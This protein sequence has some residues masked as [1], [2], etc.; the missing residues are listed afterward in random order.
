MASTG[1]AVAHRVASVHSEGYEALFGPLPRLD[2]L[3]AVPARGGDAAARSAL[4]K[5]SS[6]GERR[7][8]GMSP[9]CQCRKGRSTL[10]LRTIRHQ[11]TPL[12]TVWARP[13]VCYGRGPGEGNDR[14]DARWRS[15]R[16]SCVHPQGQGMHRPAHRRRPAASPTDHTTIRASAVAGPSRMTG[17]ERGRVIERLAGRA[18]QRR[19]AEFSR[20]RRRARLTPESALQRGS[21]DSPRSLEARAFP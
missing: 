8:G 16:A 6:D 11:P 13:Y 17:D 20:C 18:V 1:W 2:E 10:F 21:T 12:R 5:R 15:R 9:L 4:G 19:A 14:P 7:S 3:P